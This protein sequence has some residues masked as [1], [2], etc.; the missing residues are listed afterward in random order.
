MIFKDHIKVLND[1]PKYKYNL[2]WK[3]N[4]WPPRDYSHANI[5]IMNLD[6]DSNIGSVSTCGERVK[7]FVYEGMVSLLR[8]C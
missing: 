4:Y 3:S 7:F 5:R 8:F 2:N 6:I 1:Y